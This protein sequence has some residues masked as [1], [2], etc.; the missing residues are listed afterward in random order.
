M[1]RIIKFLAVVVLSI[2][3]ILGSISSAH[4]DSITNFTFTYGTVGSPINVPWSAPINLPL[5]NIVGGSLKSVTFNINADFFV[6][7]QI[8]NSLGVT[9]DSGARFRTEYS[10]DLSGTSLNSTLGG[11]G[12]INLFD[13]LVYSGSAFTLGAHSISNLGIHAVETSGPIIY[14]VAK[15]DDLSAFTNARSILFTASSQASAIDKVNVT[16][17]TGG[18]VYQAAAMTFTVTY[19]YTGTAA[20]WLTPEPSVGILFGV[21][22]LACCGLQFRTRQRRNRNKS[23]ADSIDV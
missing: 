4:A 12:A 23:L 14:S 11:G 15:G 13:N 17:E 3:A 6:T 10:V 2:G 5:L 1:K 19:D 16:Y 22:G 9:A 8:N 18:L 21:G 20:V 7:N